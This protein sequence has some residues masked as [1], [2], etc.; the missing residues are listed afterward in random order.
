[1]FHQSVSTIILR[2]RK[3]VTNILM[4]G[5]VKFET[6]QDQIYVWFSLAHLPRLLEYFFR[7]IF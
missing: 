7:V 1:M 5:F 4:I 3:I 2:L 6:K